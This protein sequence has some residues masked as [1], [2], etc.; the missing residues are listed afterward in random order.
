MWI[1]DLI[2]GAKY[3]LMIVFCHMLGF[4]IGKIYNITAY[5]V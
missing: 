3:D 5:L 2:S 4:I 1:S